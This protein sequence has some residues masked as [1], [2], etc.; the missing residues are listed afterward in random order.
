MNTPEIKLS[1]PEYNQVMAADKADYISRNSPRGRLSRSNSPSRSRNRTPSPTSYPLGE[2]SRNSPRG[3]L[4]R[5]NSPSRSRNPSPTSYPLG[6]NSQNLYPGRVSRGHSPSRSRNRTP[7]PTNYPQSY[8]QGRL[9]RSHSP[10]RPTPTNYPPGH[11][12]NYSLPGGPS[13]VT[14][15]PVNVVVAQVTPRQSRV[16]CLTN[17]RACNK[18]VTTHVTMENSGLT[19]CCCCLIFCLGGATCCLCLL[20]YC[21]NFTKDAEHSCPVCRRHLGVCRANQ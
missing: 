10:H 15:Q 7:S 4:S 20:P 5:S 13:V 2:I 14:Q 9:S 12:P 8:D 16:P 21:T 17:C 3:R 18:M 1:P 11:N 19:H 6:H